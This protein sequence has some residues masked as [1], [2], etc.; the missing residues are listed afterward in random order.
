MRIKYV[1][2]VGLVRVVRV[3]VSYVVFNLYFSDPL[4]CGSERLWEERGIACP[5]VPYWGRG[6][7][8]T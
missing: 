1:I 7:V 8:C 6:V 2:I 5:Y 4:L 3:R